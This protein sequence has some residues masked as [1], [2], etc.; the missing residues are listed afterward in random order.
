MPAETARLILEGDTSQLGNDLDQNEQRLNAFWERMQRVMQTAADSIGNNVNS[1]LSSSIDK[2]S[3]NLSAG[4]DKIDSRFKETSEAIKESTDTWTNYLVG[5]WV[6]LKGA[7]IL[8]TP[9]IAAFKLAFGLVTDIISLA[10]SGIIGLVKGLVSVIAGIIKGGASIV[11]GAFSTVFGAVKTVVET[12]F[13]NLTAVLNAFFSQMPLLT[14]GL[15]DGLKAGFKELMD[16]EKVQVRMNAQLKATGEL[17]GFSSA[18]LQRMAKDLQGVSGFSKDAAASAQSMLLQFFNVR[19]DIFKDALTTAS[20]LATV[21]G[22]DLASAAK[23]L[24]SALNDPIAGV[25]K[26]RDMG[27]LLWDSEAALIQQLTLTG[28]V[29]EA[30]RYLLD[31]LSQ[32]IGGAAAEA[33]KTFW[34]QIQLANH[35]LTEMWETIAESLTPY[36][37]KLIPY[38]ISSA[39]KVTEWAENF[40]DLSG[41]IIAWA[42]STLPVLKDWF[43]KIQ[44]FARDAFASVVDFATQA[45]SVFETAWGNA[46]EAFL[47]FTDAA[48]VMSK[49]VKVYLMEIW[50]THFD[51]LQTLWEKTAAFAQGVMYK[52]LQP[53]AD[54]IDSLLSKLPGTGESTV[55]NDLLKAKKEEAALDAQIAERQAKIR[56]QEKAAGRGPGE[57]DALKQ[58]RAELAEL[59]ARASGSSA[60]FLENFQKNLDKN[61]VAVDGMLDWTGRQLDELTKNREKKAEKEGP[62]FGRPGVPNLIPNKSTAGQ[63][64]GLEDVYNRIFQAAAK[65]PD[66][67]LLQQQVDLTKAN[68]AEQRK[69]AA[70]QAAAATAAGAVV[71]KAVSQLPGAVYA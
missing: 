5:W 58:A 19:G 71:A 9:F 55:A 3:A 44:S 18:A 34:G 25:Q 42:E 61:K 70:E 12:V 29:A 7:G 16:F 15:T 24:G 35:A 38:I 8:L 1:T 4:L 13:K 62:N 32:S 47:A 45:Y 20:D 53:V 21:M 33:T 56:A 30:Q 46:P 51:T 48:L 26:L 57:S 40:K 17:A 41:D 66:I 65:G 69:W 37:E 43:E 36:L 63:F 59:E 27:L 14:V 2:M 64:E 23:D 54:L 22:T 52:A 49:K 10:I 11:V 60:P 39:E 50:E 6:W 68:H 28:R 31:R 67:V